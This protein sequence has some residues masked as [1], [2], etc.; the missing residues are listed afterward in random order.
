M[1]LYFITPGR[2][3]LEAAL[4]FGCSAKNSSSAI[5]FFG[6]GLKFAIATLLRTGHEITVHIGDDAPLKFSSMPKNFRD[7]DFQ[8]V[9]LDGKPL[10]FTTDL[11][12]NWEVW[13]AF[14]ELHS[15][16]LD[17]G[18]VTALE[19]LDVGDVGD[20]DSYTVIEVVGDLIEHVYKHHLHEIFCKGRLIDSTPEM[21]VL[22]GASQYLYYRGVRV[23][24]L[25]LPSL[26]T[27]NLLSEQSLT[28]DRTLQNTYNL[29]YKMAE[30]ASKLTDKNYLERILTAP[31]ASF[32]SDFIYR[33]SLT[34]SDSFLSAVQRCSGT[35]SLNKSAI[36]LARFCSGEAE[37]PVELN[38]VQVKQLEKAI[39]FLSKIGYDI[40][41]YSIHTVDL[42]KGQTGEARNGKIL[43]SIQSFDRGTK[44]VAET[45][46]EELIHLR[47]GVYDETRAMQDALL[48][49]IITLGETLI[50]EPI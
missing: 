7:K 29:D 48:R 13:M 8:I 35:M 36:K 2:I 28:E 4:T 38:A 43:L 6:T 37:K 33:E 17:E 20:V 10:G 50:G 23:H 34:P 15:N 5:G 18:G 19:L 27:Y 46:L 21:E 49:E 31:Q 30:Y 16:T 25:P 40:R 12:K 41:S 44:Y 26:H 45:L 39:Q 11:G 14:R 3:D 22:Q 24:K 32:E 42:P 9:H 47:E 1:T